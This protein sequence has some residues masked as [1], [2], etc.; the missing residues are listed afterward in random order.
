MAKRRT[1]KAQLQKEKQRADK[2]QKRCDDLR[3]IVLRLEHR[4]NALDNVH[5]VRIM[6][7]MPMGMYHRLPKREW[8]ACAF[9]DFIMRTEEGFEIF[10]QATFIDAQ[11]KAPTPYSRIPEV[12]L[13]MEIN[14]GI[15]RVEHPYRL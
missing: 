1:L 4:A 6:S 3:S 7:I 10:N 13:N 2:L 11:E 15:P 9:K 14:I 12:V 8:L 5:P